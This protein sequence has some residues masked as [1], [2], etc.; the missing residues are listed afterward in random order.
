M[1]PDGKQFV[2]TLFTKYSEPSDIK[3]GVKQVDMSGGGMS[4][5]MSGV[6]GS[7][8]YARYDQMETWW[9]FSG[10]QQTKAASGYDDKLYIQVFGT[11]PTLDEINMNLFTRDI[12]EKDASQRKAADEQAMQRTKSVPR[13][14]GVMPKL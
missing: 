14:N 9:Y 11:A 4:G 8:E 2:G 3:S 1:K 5:Y 6:L 12:G 10:G 7:T 13:N